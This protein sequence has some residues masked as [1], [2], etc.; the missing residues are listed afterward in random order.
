MDRKVIAQRD[1]LQTKVGT[2]LNPTVG[3]AAV[4]RCVQIIGTGNIC[5]LSFMCPTGQHGGSLVVET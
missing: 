2:I 5:F 4:A 3:E 1:I